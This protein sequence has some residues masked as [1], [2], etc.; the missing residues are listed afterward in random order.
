[1]LLLIVLM[2]LTLFYFKDTLSS[3]LIN[4]DYRPGSETLLPDSG[5]ALTESGGDVLY[6]MDDAELTKTLKRA[7]RYY[8]G[9]EDNKARYELNKIR[10]SNAAEDIR[11]KALS[12]MDLLSEPSIDNLETDYSYADVAR[13]PWL[14]DGCWVLWKGMTANIEYEDDAIRF[15]YL[16]GFQEG[17]VLEGRVGVEIPFLTVMEPLPLELLARVEA[18]NGSFILVGKTLHFLR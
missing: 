5:R 11:Q 15:D 12:L 17:R 7:L 4:R 13:A 18:K 2:G 3:R 9:Y 6:P 10:Y 14:Y 16:V 1:M 8:Q